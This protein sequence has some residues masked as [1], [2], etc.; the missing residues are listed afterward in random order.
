MSWRRCSVAIEVYV[1]CVLASEYFP[2]ARVMKLKNRRKS[3][4][5]S[6][7]SF[8]IYL[9]IADVGIESTGLQVL[10]YCLT[11]RHDT[12]QTT[13]P[14][15]QLQEFFTPVNRRIRSPPPSHP[16][17][18]PTVSHSSPSSPSSGHPTYLFLK[19]S[20]QAPTRIASGYPHPT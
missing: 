10:V 8:P 12:R 4:S 20:N 1:C 6:S 19:A 15:P 14:S 2:G 11:Q 13:T 5:A 17:H 9:V 18:H 3:S 7:S 16:I